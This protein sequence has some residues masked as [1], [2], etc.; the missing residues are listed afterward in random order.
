MSS[1]SVSSEINESAALMIFTMALPPDPAVAVVSA[2]PPHA[3][4]G[5]HQFFRRRMVL[6]EAQE[7]RP[8]RLPPLPNTKRSLLRAF[9][10]ARRSKKSAHSALCTT[11]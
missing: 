5:T 7:Q 9:V 2:L 8:P 1:C 3:N 11:W 4:S 6:T 10:R